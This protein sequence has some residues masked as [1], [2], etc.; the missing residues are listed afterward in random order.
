M[1]L[2]ELEAAERDA[3]P[4][5]WCVH[6]NGTSVWTGETYDSNTK[7]YLLFSVP[8]VAPKRAVLDADFLVEL[9]NAAPELFARLRKMEEALKTAD[10]WL[11]LQE[12]LRYRRH[13]LRQY[14]ADADWNARSGRAFRASQRFKDLLRELLPEPTEKP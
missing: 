14:E 13:D 11:K 7:Q 10:E 8:V 2:D 1:D 4:G 9:R 5:P 12:G 6:P 3:T